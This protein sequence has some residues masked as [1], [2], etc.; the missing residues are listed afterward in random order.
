MSKKLMLS[1]ICASVLCVSPTLHANTMLG[2][3]VKGDGWSTSEMDRFNTAA[4]K[5]MAMTNLFTTFDYH[6]G[7]L[8]YQSDNIISRGG[9]PMISWMP[10]TSSRSDDNILPEIAAGQWD[11]YLD[12]WIR[13]FNWWRSGVPDGK[14]DTIMLRFG[15]E[16][17]GVWYPWGNDPESYKAAWQYI[18]N[19]FEQAGLNAHIEWVWSIN[20]VDVDDVN[21]V[22]QYYPGDAYVDWTSIDGYNWGSNYSFSSWKSFDETFSS[23]YTTLIDNYPTKPIVIAEVGSAEPHDVPNPAYGQD[24]DNSD[25]AES[26]EAWVADMFNRIEESYPA[27]RAVTWFNI[28]KELSWA[29]HNNNNTG[30]DA[31]KVMTNTP[32]YTSAYTDITQ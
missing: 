20:N 2:A 1:A 16:M 14:H 7:Y 27:I 24:G 12:R 31:Y 19:Y 11:A 21:D 25:Y 4:G 9:V 32:H 26:K 6:W 30:L 23:A 8:K 18:H 22:T 13:G 17:N 28:N 29:L 3:Y 10:V 5:P 15:H